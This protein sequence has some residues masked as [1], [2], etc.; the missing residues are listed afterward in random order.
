MEYPDCVQ[1]VEGCYDRFLQNVACL[2]A[3]TGKIYTFA[4]EKGVKK[5]NEP[6]RKKMNTHC[7]DA[8]KTRKNGSL[9]LPLA[10][11][12]GLAVQP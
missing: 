7:Q 9:F 10:V 8:D 11:P 2:L 5:A 1:S 6:L 12:W 4:N 3:R